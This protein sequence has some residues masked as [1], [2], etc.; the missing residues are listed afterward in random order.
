MTRSRTGSSASTGSNQSSS[1]RDRY[2]GKISRN[3]H[4][5]DDDEEEE[6][7]EEVDTGSEVSEL[8]E[9]HEHN[10]GYNNTPTIK[11]FDTLLKYMLREKGQYREML[12]DVYANPQTHPLIVEAFEHMKQLKPA[13][14]NFLWPALLKRWSKYAHRI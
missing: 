6:E 12:L 4:Y 13:E 3:T 9:N 14:Q 11:T 8:D 10:N 5:T 7:E 2:S 1:N